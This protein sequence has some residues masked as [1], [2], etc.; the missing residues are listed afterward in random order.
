MAPGEWD[1]DGPHDLMTTAALLGSGV[2]AERRLHAIVGG[3]AGETAD[4][5]LVVVLDRIA[6]RHAWRAE[7]LLARLPLLRELPVERVVV[8][9]GGRLGVELDRLADRDGDAARVASWSS[10]TTTSVQLYRD[11]LGR[12]TEV[13]DAP[14]RR[15]LP[16]VIDSLEEDILAVNRRGG[17]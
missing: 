6:M 16:L 14:L 5:S 15:W 2:W 17:A 13:S 8:G 4:P 12:T 7:V 11:H 9:P 1:S 10:V 3:W